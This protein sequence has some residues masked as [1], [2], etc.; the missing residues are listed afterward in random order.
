MSV[1]QKIAPDKVWLKRRSKKYSESPIKNFPCFFTV[2][3]FLKVIGLMLNTP[4]K[5]RARYGSK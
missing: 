1:D 2:E 4:T 5:E 3:S